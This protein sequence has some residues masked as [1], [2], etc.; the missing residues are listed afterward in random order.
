LNKNTVAN[1]ALVLFSLAFTLLLAEGA[2]RIYAAAMSM[3]R[4]SGYDAETGWN[5][6][7]N[8]RSLEHKEVDYLVQI[9]SHGLRDVEYNYDKPK[10]VYR[11]VA[12]GDSFVFGYGGVEHEELF[13]EVLESG[14]HNTQVINMGT[15]AFSTDQEYLYL[16]RDG[17]RYQADVLILFMFHND[18]KFAFKSFDS[19]ANKPKGY[20][21]QSSDGLV[22]H[23]PSPSWFYRLA[24]YSYLLGFIER[25]FH[26]ERFLYQGMETELDITE[27]IEI[28]RAL[29]VAMDKLA[30]EHGASFV[31]AYIPFREQDQRHLVQNIALGLE[32]SHDIP[33]LDL[34]ATTSFR[35]PGAATRL[36][37]RQDIHLNA[38]G[39]QAVAKHTREFL[40]E[41]QI[42]H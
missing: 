5:L 14:L 27:R 15:P 17:M 32:S 22:F 2:V 12:L 20:V 28:F 41:R 6:I 37:F 34:Q 8:S 39:H 30:R 11:I 9:N 42:L 19:T 36:Y 25:K 40:R 31:T 13:T 38:A 3:Q 23:P 33:F 10:G 4:I 29:L 35:D 16:K 26:L 7:P 24:H 18:F 21:R 1:A